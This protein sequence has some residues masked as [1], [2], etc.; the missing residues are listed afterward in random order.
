MKSPDLSI[1]PA[2]ST[3]TWVE[4]A[5]KQLKSAEALKAISWESLDIKELK[6][7][8][9]AADVNALTAQLAFFQHLP[10]HDWKLFQRIQIV[11]ERAANKEAINALVGGCDGIIFES[12]QA[13]DF[14]VLL[15]DIDLSICEVS[16]LHQEIKGASGMNPGNCLQS[17]E[18]TTP[19][20]QIQSIVG[21][22]SELHTWVE[23]KSFTDFFVE[24][25]T[26]RA[27]RYVL[28]ANHHS[29]TKIHT[30]ISM[31]ASTEHQWFLNTSAGLASILGGSY[32]IDFPTSEG[33]T[34]IS[35]N[36][37][38]II[39]EESG[40]SEYTDQ[41]GGSYFVEELTHHII[42]EVMH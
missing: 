14:G 22:L 37:G 38:N 12:S 7:Y 29:S 25:A 40:I 28:D 35:R 8:Y 41:C 20:Q 6:P 33:D 9:D 16:S 26:I 13:V 11:D 36:V 24:I 17:R 4:E 18:A 39:R 30:S 2:V 31:H 15:K 27:L 3:E 34:R 5:E 19:V 1:F 42:E 10:A 21:A 32:S 23:R